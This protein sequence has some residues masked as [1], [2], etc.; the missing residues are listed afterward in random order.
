MWQRLSETSDTTW[1]TKREEHW[2]RIAIVSFTHDAIALLAS[3]LPTIVHLTEL[4]ICRHCL[5]TFC[6]ILKEKLSVLNR[7]FFRLPFSSPSIST[8]TY[9]VILQSS[10][11]SSSLSAFSRGLICA[12]GDTKY[13][14]LAFNGDILGHFLNA[15]PQ[16]VVLFLKTMLHC[17]SFS[18][19]TISTMTHLVTP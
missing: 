7:R 12:I 14:A 18:L 2:N 9:F 10:D 4:G 17:C 15:S 19:R 5:V 13:T 3:G 1:E 11:R 6:V 8:M 16:T